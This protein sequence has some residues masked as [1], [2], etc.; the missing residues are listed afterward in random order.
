MDV[1]NEKFITLDALMYYKLKADAAVQAAI[2]AAT[3]G[4]ASTD[5]VES[6]V[7]AAVASALTY[8]GAKATVAELPSS[9]NKVGDVWHVAADECEYAW[10]GSEWEALGGVLD[11]TWDSVSGKPSTFAPSAHTHTVG[12]LSG[13]LPVSKGGTGATTAESARSALGAAPSSHGHAAMTGAS[14]TSA[15]AAGFVPAPSAGSQDKLLRGD[16]TWA[17]LAEATNA[18]IDALF[19]E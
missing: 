13:T 3:S 11:V 14:S 15:G 16:G 2:A 6:A 12:D 5:D 7:S 1:S 17:A 9:E 19:D 4:L 18:D 8:K 10:D